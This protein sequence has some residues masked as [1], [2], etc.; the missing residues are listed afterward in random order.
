MKR[1]EMIEKIYDYLCCDG[2]LE[3]SL[4]KNENV[5]FTEDHVK[6]MSKDIL[7]II[8]E[9]GMLPPNTDGGIPG[10]DDIDYESCVWELENE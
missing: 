5:K 4:P 2:V 3:Y 10:F 1:S 6:D 8:E 7:N 9:A